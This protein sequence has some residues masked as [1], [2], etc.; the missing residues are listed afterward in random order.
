MWQDMV[1]ARG[2]YL[3]VYVSMCLTV[4]PDPSYPLISHPILPVLD[5]IP[6][7]TSLQPEIW[8]R[9]QTCWLSLLLVEPLGMWAYLSNGGETQRQRERERKKYFDE[10]DWQY[11]LF[12]PAARSRRIHNFVPWNGSVWVTAY[13]EV[14]PTAKLKTNK[15]TTKQLLLRCSAEE[16][17]LLWPSLWG[18]RSVFFSRKAGVGAVVKLH[19]A[20]QWG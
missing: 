20:S 13:E 2:C 3:C 18:G 5:D 4:Y 6:L 17:R 1:P 15:Q 10:F 16:R 12:R 7:G 11:S 8:F 19:A 9:L 14:H